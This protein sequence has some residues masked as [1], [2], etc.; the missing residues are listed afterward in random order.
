VELRQLREF[1]AVL[2][3]GSL[4]DAAR[5]LKT[6]QPNLTKSMQ[7]LEKT[8]GGRLFVRSPQGMKPTALARV[9][10]SRAR[11]ISGEVERAQREVGEHLHAQRGRVVIGSGPFLT[12]IVFQRALAHFREAHPN[13]QITIYHG[14]TRDIFPAIKTGV[15]D[16]GLHSPPIWLG[17]DELGHEVLMHDVRVGIAASARHPLASRRR[18]TL[19]DVAAASW[20]LPSAPDYMRGKLDAIF[21]AAALPVIRPSIECNSVLMMKSM[22]QGSDLVGI[23]AERV[24]EEELR[25]KTL[26]F[27]AVPELTWRFDYNAIY[28]LG[29]PLPPAA[30]A[31]LAEI[32][33]SCAG[34]RRGN[35]AEK[36]AR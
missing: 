23:F 11:V 25:S 18:V 9:L 30:Q 35:A 16:F 26:K 19:K 1:L 5:Q 12:H 21:A 22:M 24:I 8:V 36:A 31:L 7:A 33:R 32:R 20:M 14:Q 10:E 27:L 29:S 2:E 28:R 3:C 13:V 6:R 4:G 34:N 15:I 17:D